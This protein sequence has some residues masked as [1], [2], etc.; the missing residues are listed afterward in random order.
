MFFSESGI[1]TNQCYLAPCLKRVAW[2]CCSGP[3][4]TGTQSA[5]TSGKQGTTHPH[6][7]EAFHLCV[8]STEQTLEVVVVH[9]SGTSSKS[10]S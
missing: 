5:S 10:L 6:W 1:L 3:V 8:A 2:N 9:A 7:R 4:E